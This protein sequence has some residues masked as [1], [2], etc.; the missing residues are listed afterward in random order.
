MSATEHP[1]GCIIGPKPVIKAPIDGGEPAKSNFC[2]DRA[3][4]VEAAD[5]SRIAVHSGPTSPAADRFRLLRMRLRNLRAVAPLKTILVT[6]PLPQDGKSTVAINLATVLTEQRSKNVLLLD[7]DLHRGSASKELGL[8]Y[9]DGASEC[10]HSGADPLAAIRRVEPLGFFALAAGNCGIETPADLLLPPTLAPILT[11]L[12]PHFDWVIIDS[13][14]VLPLTDALSVAQSA[15]G[16]LL[17]ARAGRTPTK[18]VE[19]AIEIL[20]RKS[21]LGVV[22]NGM[23]ESAKSYY[24]YRHYY[25]DRK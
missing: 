18:A 12:V 8:D 19:E 11:A 17:V 10:L 16:T 7:L 9:A 21:I 20:G 25:K 5:V 22:L 14:P 1:D 13:P 15:D 2:L 3:P 4:S 24:K 23:E 6:S